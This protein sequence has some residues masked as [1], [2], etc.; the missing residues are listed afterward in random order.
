[1]PPRLVVAAV[2]VGWLATVSW[3]ASERW[4]SPDRPGQPPGLVVDL[5]DEVAPQQGSWL[6]FR[7]G[8]RVG[9]AETRLAPRKDGLFELTTRLRE[10]DLE[11]GTLPVKATLIHTTRVVTRAGELV[12]LESRSEV[13]IRTGGPDPKVNAT[14]KGQF[15]GDEFRRTLEVDAVAGRV[16][17]PLEP[18]RFGTKRVFSP[19]LPL[20][21]YPPLRAG[22]SWRETSLDLVGDA[23]SDAVRRAEPRV[24]ADR[25]PDRPAPVE[26]LARVRDRREELVTPRGQRR[27]CWVIDHS[28]DGP[29]AKTWVDEADGKVMRH[30]ATVLGQVFTLVRD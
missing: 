12:S 4:W 15:V 17:E 16:A 18:V 23:I 7:E 20:Y 2:V 24:A 30:E 5:S 14:L 29:A 25:L 28:D 11:A 19:L 26:V 6:L 27:S 10:L 1:M 13:L 22:Q 9:S 8:E 3:L 21:K